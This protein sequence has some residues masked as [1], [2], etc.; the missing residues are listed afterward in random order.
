MFES[1][2]VKD[3][4]DSYVN[5]LGYPIGAFYGFDQAN[6][7]LR[8]VYQ[9]RNTK[10]VKMPTDGKGHI[11]KETI[12]SDSW[13]P[14]FD[15]VVTDAKV[16]HV[17]KK[18]LVPFARRIMPPAL[19]DRITR[20]T[21]ARSA[22]VTPVQG[23]RRPWGVMVL[24]SKHADVIPQEVNVLEQYA[25]HAALAMRIEAAKNDVIETAGDLKRE[26]DRND[27]LNRELDE[28]RKL[29]DG[30][31]ADP[32]NT[33][34]LQATIDELRAQNSVLLEKSRKFEEAVS[35]LKGLEAE[36]GG[37]ERNEV[38]EPGKSFATA[39]ERLKAAQ[40]RY[41]DEQKNAYEARVRAII[42]SYERMIA[43][44]KNN[45]SEGGENR[46]AAYEARVRAVID[47]YEAR[48]AELRR[49]APLTVGAGFEEIGKADSELRAAI[50]EAAKSELKTESLRNRI[51]DDRLRISALE[52]E[53]SESNAVI[54]AL[55][56]RL[57]E[58]N[59]PQKQL[60]ASLGESVR[61]AESQVAI[62]KS[63]YEEKTMQCQ[64]LEA[65]LAHTARIGVEDLAAAV[66]A[67][68]AYKHEIDDLKAQIEALESKPAQDAALLQKNAF[69]ENEI[70]SLRTALR[71]KTAEF[72]KLCFENKKFDD[73]K[74]TLQETAANRVAELEAEIRGLRLAA[75]EDRG[76]RT[77]PDADD[78]RE[79]AYEARVLAITQSYEKL[80]GEKSREFETKIA[81]L[82]KAAAASGKS[83]EALEKIGAQNRLLKEKLEK[84]SVQLEQAKEA[85]KVPAP[86]DEAA[87]KTLA[88]E[89]ETLRRE[90]ETLQKEL[91]ACSTA[92]AAPAGRKKTD[93]DGAD[94]T[95][96]KPKRKPGGKNVKVS[97]DKVEA[98]N[99]R[100]QETGISRENLARILS[101]YGSAD[102]KEFSELTENQAKM[103]MSK[104]MD[105]KWLAQMGL[106][107]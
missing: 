31:T 94:E 7:S 34:K 17:K 49:D 76:A 89:N 79:K 92:K 85:A 93:E 28:L 105:D 23:L 27:E 90:I 107:S 70:E 2:A 66:K 56:L 67:N 29:K 35:K 72:Q 41:L 32:E 74:A 65:E 64:K 98:F 86:E 77:T 13:G 43:G 68:R 44:F 71:T 10:V 9:G 81:E 95:T 48:L 63:W 36:K 38:D 78:G 59:D 58:K 97:P 12:S 100:V 5:D 55:R 84:L 83:A 73:V 60:I 3:V 88:A 62:W 96:E 50:D 47:S 24:F 61:E 30:D 21:P 82:E 6:A 1:Q 42:E 8:L 33:E 104:I 75:D 51:A 46:F 54:E 39:I 11:L 22:L 18:D 57:R 53:I 19:A 99:R 26:K 80:L 69:L 106:V 4:F 103:L 14:F 40:E 15:P 25:K 20:D 101:V 52:K 37:V 91:A 16:L 102:V 87:Q 45:A